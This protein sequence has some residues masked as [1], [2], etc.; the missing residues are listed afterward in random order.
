MSQRG[1]RILPLGLL[2]EER[3]VPEEEVYWA[4]EEA[5]EE[6]VHWGALV[7]L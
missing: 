7:N 3:L 6:A 5:K 2:E 1:R 4:E